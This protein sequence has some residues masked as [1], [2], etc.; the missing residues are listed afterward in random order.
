[1]NRER[2]HR[3]F[4]F[5]E[6]PFK[7]EE[8][9]KVLKYQITVLKMIILLCTFVVSIIAYI[10]FQEH[11]YIN[12][13]L[14]SFMVVILIIGYYFINKKKSYFKIVAR[15]IVLT[16]FAVLITLL[17][18]V[19]DALPI[20]LW[21]PS[22]VFILFFFL[23]SKEAWRW[24]R[25]VLTILLISHFSNVHNAP[26]NNTQFFI[27][28]TN[29]IFISIVLHW[30]EKMKA[31]NEEYNLK[32]QNM[33]KKE[34]AIHTQALA[35]SN[36]NLATLNETLEE[37][38]Q[39]EIEKNRQQE[40]Y[41]LQ[42]SRMAQMGEMLSMI[43]HQWRQ[44][45][46]AISSTAANLELKIEME[47]Y[48]KE[49]FLTRVKNISS[50]SQ[51]LSET[52]EDFRNFFKSNKEVSETTLEEIVNS[53]LTIVQSSLSSNHID[54]ITH[55]ES[56]ESFFTYKNELKQVLL[57]IIKN[58]EDI[59]IENRVKKPQIFI[60]TLSNQSN[61]ILE[62]GDNGGGIKDE[63][64]AH[65]FDPYFTTKGKRDGT[66]LGL[67]ISKTIVE[68]HCQGRLSVTNTKVGAK[69]SIILNKNSTLKEQ[70]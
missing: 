56:Y 30:Y 42:Q 28:F 64:M 66:G 3:L 19:K 16:A 38:V 12:A 40:S 63:I 22:I 13:Q 44:P 5:F 26:L 33:L 47:H 31:D 46:S 8:S 20:V 17:F 32:Y 70:K 61:L 52:I 2:Y 55:F 23:N 9:E 6:P 35:D 27:F 48:D 49:L 15:T 54:I 7:L 68:G 41:M 58:A 11:A 36:K 62:V 59:M 43:A 37:R 1:M 34:I 4:T 45:L 14:D 67:Y 53:T 50:Y 69:F 18:I 65:I 57:N 21:F 60:H 29:L 51:H 39:N 24:M 25:V 10:R